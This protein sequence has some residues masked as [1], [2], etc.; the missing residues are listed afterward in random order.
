MGNK[1]NLK[2]EDSWETNFLPD[3]DN[4]VCG[5][6]MVQLFLKYLHPWRPVFMR[7]PFQDGSKEAD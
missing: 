1:I 5:D 6:K 7:D 3:T 2:I 4:R